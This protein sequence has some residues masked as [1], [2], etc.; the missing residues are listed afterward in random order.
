MSHGRKLNKSATYLRY[1]QTT[2]MINM[3]SYIKLFNSGTYNLEVTNSYIV[4]LKD[5]LKEGT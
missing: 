2:I 1:F 5:H 3:V 4:V